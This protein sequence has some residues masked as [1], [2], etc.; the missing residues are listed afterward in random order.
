MFT[1]AAF[2]LIF[3]LVVSIL[4]HNISA[5]TC[6]L[7]LQSMY[8]CL[9][10]DAENDAIRFMK[11]VETDIGLLTFHVKNNGPEELPA[12]VIGE[13][14]HVKMYISALGDTGSMVD[15]YEVT[16]FKGGES[17]TNALAVSS[18]KR[19]PT[20]EYNL[21]YP[22]SLCPTHSH[23]CLRIENHGNYT[24]NETTNNFTCLPFIDG[25]DASGLTNCPSDVVP[26]SIKVIRPTP[27][28]FSVDIAVNVTF[29]VALK[30]AG[31]TKIPGSTSELDNIVFSSVFI[32]NAPDE[33]ATVK[34]DLTDS[35]EYT[36]D[37]VSTGI[38]EWGEV[39]FTNLN[40]TILI[41]EIQCEEYRYFCVKLQKGVNATFDD[42]DSNNLL[43]SPFGDGGDI[44]VIHC[45]MPT[46][47][48]ATTAMFTTHDDGCAERP[49]VIIITHPDVTGSST[50]INMSTCVVVIAT[51]ISF[52]LS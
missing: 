31:G 10:P 33:S 17:K 39:T 37:D 20:F 35:L 2:H 6:D 26:T 34:S 36:R 3:C 8:F 32:A 52:K 24:D 25:P 45:P 19:Y 9:G 18:D 7:S 43:C 41:P 48:V 40:V 21:K 1:M 16:T 47:T 11:D 13:H 4:A 42:D 49:N 46:T 15:P 27:A 50:V 30:N 23:L 38:V 28:N 14:F 44:G 12:S 51:L 22:S 5:L 29:D